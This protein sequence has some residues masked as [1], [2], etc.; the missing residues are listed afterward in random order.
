MD[1]SEIDKIKK[2]IGKN[3]FQAKSIVKLVRQNSGTTATVKIG[4][5]LLYNSSGYFE[6]LTDEEI[7]KVVNEHVGGYFKYIEIKPP[8]F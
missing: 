1:K 4:I 8:S 7:L 6:N 5:E 3:L 2:K